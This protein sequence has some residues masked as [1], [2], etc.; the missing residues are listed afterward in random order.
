MTVHHLDKPDAFLQKMV[1]ACFPGYNG[2]TFKLSTDVPSRLDSYWSGGSK[3]SYVIYKL[4]TGEV[5]QVHSNHPFFESNQPSTLNELPVG[6]AIVKHTI[7]QGKDLGI[8]IYGNAENITPLLPPAE[9]L[10]VDEDAVLFFTRSLKS[11]YAGVKNY[12]FVNARRETGITE[13]RWEKAKADLIKRKLLNKA[14]AI[15]PSGRNAVGD[16]H[17]YKRYGE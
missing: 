2:R 15:T 6:F 10:S 16:R 8:T 4:E 9:E 13:E 14:G 1:K 3:D 12:R 17:S 7:F 5:A 11:S